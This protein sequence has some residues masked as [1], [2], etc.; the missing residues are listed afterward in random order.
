MPCPRPLGRYHSLVAAQPRA[1]TLI[2]GDGI[3]PE[4]ISA[5]V[6]VIEA[7]GARIAWDRQSAGAGAVKRFGTPVP[8]PL[9]KSLER[10]KVSWSEVCWIA[11]TTAPL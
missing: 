10:T 8:E 6:T 5:A 11:V 4:V 1:V 2:A 3:G 9:I 7:T